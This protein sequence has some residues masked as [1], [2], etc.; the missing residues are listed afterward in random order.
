MA[1][2]TS[3]YLVNCESSTFGHSTIRVQRTGPSGGDSLIT[4]LPGSATIEV[5]DK[6][7][8]LIN[9]T[10]KVNVDHINNTVLIESGNKKLE[11]MFKNNNYCSMIAHLLDGTDKKNI[12]YSTEHHQDCVI[13][14]VKN[15]WYYNTP[16]ISCSFVSLYGDISMVSTPYW[17]EFNAMFDGIMVRYIPESNMFPKI[18]SVYYSDETKNEEY[19]TIGGPPMGSSVK[20][21]Y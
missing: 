11:M 1:V 13:D 16:S 6:D 18:S 14:L 7:C 2:E 3:F 4:N 5:V 15:G 12:Y 21:A 8:Y 9:G 19:I 20:S 17:Y 10:T